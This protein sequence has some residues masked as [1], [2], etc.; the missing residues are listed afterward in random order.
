MDKTKPAQA[1]VLIAGRIFP[2]P[3]VPVTT[4][5][6]M[7]LPALLLE[8]TTAFRVLAVNLTFLRLSTDIQFP[9]WALEM[10]I[11]LRVIRKLPAEDYTYVLN[12]RNTRS[13]S[14]LHGVHNTKAINT[15]SL[16]RSIL[17]HDVCDVAF[18][19]RYHVGPPLDTTKYTVSTR[20]MLQLIET[21]FRLSVSAIIVR[22]HAPRSEYESG[23][24]VRLFAVPTNVRFLGSPAFSW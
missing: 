6:A 16:H 8:W 14:I 23:H 4:K 1:G 7:F 3:N 15:I 13:C 19:C 10:D 22:L 21:V 12:T 9:S 17:I 18:C 2:T 20:R 24:M 11:L 5:I